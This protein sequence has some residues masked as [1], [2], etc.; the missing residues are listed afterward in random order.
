MQNSFGR[1]AYFAFIMAILVIC[2]LHLSALTS[3]YWIKG[4]VFDERIHGG[5][6]KA[7]N[8]FTCVSILDNAQQIPGNFLL[9]LLLLDTT[10]LLIYYTLLIVHYTNIFV[11]RN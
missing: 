10:T 5:L 3:T 8:Q 7:C 6:W 9:D 1:V 11:A 4:K 2:T